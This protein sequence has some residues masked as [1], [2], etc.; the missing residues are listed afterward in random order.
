MN[1]HVRV[2]CGVFDPFIASAVSNVSVVSHG[3]MVIEDEICR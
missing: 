2:T 3:K 1:W